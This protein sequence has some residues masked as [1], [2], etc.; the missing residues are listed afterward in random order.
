MSQYKQ[1]DIFKKAFDLWA[2]ATN[3]NINEVR[4]SKDDAVDILISFVRG[5]HSDAYPFDGEGG[6]L[7]HAYYPHNNLG[8]LK[9]VLLCIFLAIKSQLQCILLN[10]H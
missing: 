6:T 5:Y 2:A 3:L 9:N 10:V 1:R 7:A 4:H 8:E